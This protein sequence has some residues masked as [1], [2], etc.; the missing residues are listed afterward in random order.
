[1][2]RG[3]VI[4]ET[5]FVL[6]HFVNRIY[7]P[8]ADIYVKS[9][10]AE[11]AEIL[12][13]SALLFAFSKIKGAS[14]S[15]PGDCRGL[16]CC[17]PAASNCDLSPSACAWC[18][19]K[20]FFQVCIKSWQPVRVLTVSPLGSTGSP[21]RPSPGRIPHSFRPGPTLHLTV[22]ISKMRLRILQTRL[23]WVL[24]KFVSLLVMISAT[25]NAC[26]TYGTPSWH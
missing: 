17:Q 4:F 16:N 6:L 26:V 9:R 18:S 24:C 5:V 13:I 3:M 14:P 19:C 7:L 8:L 22:C 15:E 21:K 20:L 10:A 23:F 11:R 25:V 2:H 1:M 12:P